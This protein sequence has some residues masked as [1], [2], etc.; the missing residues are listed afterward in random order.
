MGFVNVW[1]GYQRLSYWGVWQRDNLCWNYHAEQ[2]VK[3]TNKR[4]YYLRKCR[5]ANLPNKIGTI[6]YCSGIHPLLEYASPVWGGL[7]KYLLDEW[8]T[9]NR[10]L[11]IIEMSYNYNLRSVPGPVAIK[12]SRTQRNANSFMAW[13]TRLLCL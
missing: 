1:R 7:P 12:R 2:T 9:Q 11:D 13:A 6:V 4:L 3:K 5:K 8:E 10:S